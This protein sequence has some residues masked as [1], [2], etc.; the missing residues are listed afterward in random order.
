MGEELAKE[1]FRRDALTK[2]RN[3]NPTI[4]N[5]KEYRPSKSAGINIV[6]M[7]AENQSVATTLGLRGLKS[8]SLWPFASRI[9]TFS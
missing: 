9:L 6:V 8:I 5:Q 1:P 2:P 4:K 7:V 3:D